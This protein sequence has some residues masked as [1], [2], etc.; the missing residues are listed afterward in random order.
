[1]HNRKISFGGEEIPANIGSTPNIIKPTRKMNV[2]Q[3]AGSNR[4]VVDMEDAWECYDQPYILFVGDGSED[5]VQE[6]I[7]EVARV[8]YK[9][10]WQ[11]LLDDYETDY[12]RLAYYQGPFDVDNRYTRLGKFDIS[13][14]CRPERFLKSGNVEIVVTSG[15]TILNP[16]GYNA[17]P[18]IHITGSGNGTLT[19]NGTTMSFTGITDYLNLDCE[20][21][22]CY[23]LPSEN[24]N[25]LMTGEF[26]VLKSGE[27]LISYTG[28]ISSVTITPKWFT[29]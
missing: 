3:I 18:M 21:Q 9:T 16:T 2:V 7:I 5:C 22:D 27:N 11:V 26:P 28:G 29:I 23:R 25:N 1:M 10:G 6:L 17:K 4:E 19:V 12:Y 24:K 13:F 15:T 20:R 8:L 14:R